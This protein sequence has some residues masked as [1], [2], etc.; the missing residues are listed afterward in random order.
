[1][2]KPSRSSLALEML[3]FSLPLMLSG[4]LQQLYSWADAFII[5]HAEGEMQLAAVGAT[6]SLCNFLSNTILGLTLGLSILAAR[7]V[8]AGRRERVRSVFV[9]FLPLLAAVYALIALGASFFLEPVLTLMDTPPEIFS[10]ALAYL[11]IILPGVPFLACYNLYAALLRALGN[12]KAA[13]YAVLLSSLTN[14]VLDI[15]L[16]AV[17]PFGVAGA[18]AAT[19]LSQI[20]M[21]VFIVLY[22]ARKEPALLRPAIQVPSLRVLAEGMRFAAPP[23]LKN[24]VTSLGNLTLQGFMNS[25]GATTVLAVTTAYRVDCITLLPIINLGAAISIM[26]AQASGAQNSRRIRAC[27]KTGSLLMLTIAV[28]L[29]GAMFSFGAVFISL[30]GVTGNALQQGRVFFQDLSIFYPVFGLS[31]VL[32]S[33]LEGVGDIT[34]CSVIGVASLALRIALSFA[35]RPILAERTIA[36]AEGIVWVTTLCVFALRMAMRKKNI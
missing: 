9:S 29:A 5:G 11:R 1:M 20:G 17:L 21:T 35:L 30:F 23:A 33:V 18:A 15:L 22:A 12:T 10:D 28:L 25:F 26:T 19:V 13:F 24:S 31:I 6:T 3:R 32:Q 34:F 4:V 8:G 7:Y 2:N 27:L 36:I 16:V 14:V